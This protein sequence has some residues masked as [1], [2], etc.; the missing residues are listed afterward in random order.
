MQVSV[1]T[2]PLAGR[3]A[4]LRAFDRA[5]ADSRRRGAVLFGPAGVGKTR[6]AEEFQARSVGGRWKGTRISAGSSR[7]VPLGAMAHLLPDGGDLT[8]AVR[9]YAAV[10]RELAGPQHNR[11]WVVLVDDLH[12]LDTASTV[13]LQYLLS[14]GVIRLIAT[15]RTGEP[16]GD[17]VDALAQG[18]AILRIDLAA[19]TPDQTEAVLRGALGAPVDRQ[20]LR[21]FA[22]SSLGNALYLRELVHSALEAGTLRHDGEIWTLTQDTP[23]VPP[24]LSDL[25]SARLAPVARPGRTALELLALC[26]PVPLA[27]LQE[28]A[29][30]EALA[31]LDEAGL[32]RV[33][34]DGQRTT[35]S[36]AHPLYGDVLRD[37]LSP[38]RRRRLLLQH[39]EQIR[40]HGGRRRS[41]AVQLAT[42]QLA[43]TGTADPELLVRGA[44]V[45]RHAHDYRQVDELLR[46][47]P[48]AHRTAATCLMNG[49]ALMNL[50]RWQHADT[51]MA[52]AEKRAVGE[53][54]RVTA[55]L[56]RTANLFWAAART[57]Q[58]IEVNEAAME[59]VAEPANLRLL[60]LDKGAML[61][62]SGRPAEGA[63]LLADV[64]AE[65]PEHDGGRPPSQTAVWEVAAFSRTTA[66][67]CGGRTD[68]A[69]EWG[70]RA[71]ATHQRL[72]ARDR[73]SRTAYSQLNPLLFAMADAGQLASARETSE[74]AM[75]DL[76]AADVTL[77]RIW[78]AW[79][80]AR[81]EWL[82]G[83]AASARRWYA[84]AVAQA[85]THR[86]LPPLRQA[87]AGLGASAALLG[88]LEAAQSAV[89]QMR[90]CPSMGF[91]AGEESLAE[92]WLL[93]GQGRPQEARSVL[94]EGAARA[95]RTGHRTSELLLLLDIARLGGAAEVT[96]RLAELEELCDGPFAAARVRLAVALAQEDPAALQA[97]AEQLEALGAFL[98]A[99]EAA[100]TAAALWLRT[101]RTRQATA[102]AHRAQACA[103]HCPGAR[104]P[105]LTPAS[106]A[107]ASR[108]LTKRE[109]QVALLAAAG[110]TSKD[111]AEALHLSVRTVDNH[112]QHVYA[113][114]GITHRG[115]LARSL[116]ALPPARKPSRRAGG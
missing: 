32:T 9:G 22:D 56:A 36:L 114:L 102:A 77:P 31:D 92:A 18:D 65:P 17:A 23:P 82:A 42:V 97:V 38:Q 75:A 74:R 95:R 81:V 1:T 25:I 55:V 78:M 96:G 101:D 5:W 58:A 87:W 76:V 98:L 26:Q 63:E 60:R 15:V 61:A 4:E 111:I 45:A 53:Q 2:W 115:H 104:T 40:A 57:E 68:E 27:D 86:F 110:T 64:E 59:Q 14:T 11:R 100:S 24:V 6:L 88:D 30:P 33:H 50:A 79:F 94:A 8:D 39:V 7:D 84:E 62:A 16:F 51:L 37:G 19:F 35:M 85:R 66:L 41:D 105:L 67:A 113:K 43:A 109:H 112:L 89:E 72:A 21:A 70:W 71:Y 90:G 34:Q 103:A 91:A 83:D 93:A 73:A 108:T 3:E 20:A 107:P 44:L 54:E 29:G 10:A 48:D 13:L 69:L 106:S 52:E 47:L 80:R 46:A 49:E 28:L 12:L 99:A 116:G